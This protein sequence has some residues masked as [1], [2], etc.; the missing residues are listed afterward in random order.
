VLGESDLL[1]ALIWL[2]V[3]TV[4]MTLVAAVALKTLLL[5]LKV[6]FRALTLPLRILASLIAGIFSILFTIIA[7]IVIVVGVVGLAITLPMLVITAVPFILIAFGICLL[8]TVFFELEEE[9]MSEYRTESDSMGTV[10]VPSESYYGAQTQRAVL[11]FP[12]SPLRFPR[13]FIRAMGLIKKAAAEANS[14]LGLLDKEIADF[15]ARAAD[16]VIEGKLDDQFVVDIFQTG[17][18]TS[19]N[20]NTN[21]VIANRAIEL[22]GGKVGSRD[23]HPN[24]HVNMSQS[25]NDVI[26][27]AIHVSALQEIE[28][29]LIPALQR[30]HDSLQGKA[31]EFDRVVK[32]GR[33]HLQDAVPIRLGQE[34]AAYASMIE[35]SITRMKLVVPHLSELAIGGTA[36]GTGL[37]CPP[38]FS[39]KVVSRLSSWTGV[40]FMEASNKFEALASKDAAVEASGMLKT[41]AC[42]L[43]KIANDLRW[44]GSGPRCGIGEILLPSI[45]PGSSIMPGKV[46]PV[47]PEA[48]TMIAAQ[49][50]GNDITISVG[51][52]S[53]NFELNVMKPVI[54]Y[55]LLQSI[56]LIGNGCL[57]LAEKCVDGLEADR[58]RCQ[59]MVEKSLAMVTSL[60]PRVGYDKAAEIAKEAYQTG[61]TV[62]EVAQDSQLLED[63]EL[64]QVLDPWSMTEGGIA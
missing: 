56:E 21:E 19:T 59:Q 5:L 16:E 39:A 48:V 6:S 27:T 13:P 11:N 33:T 54:A 38:E 55:N 17:S 2:A 35:H 58:E 57:V 4:G 62:R 43:M 37:N 42:S 18:G 52:Q 20:M 15:I 28:E 14:E 50:I 44:L 46:N 1:E 29:R 30:L 40:G 47:I 3:L 63:Q 12:I 10:Q 9:E 60:V 7:P 51:G 45:Q 8:V 53:G 23:V 41:V 64:E 32:I 61:R 49:V 25:S 34:F 31:Q 36:V 22:R 24:D 26:P